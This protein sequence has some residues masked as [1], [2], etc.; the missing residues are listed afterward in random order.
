[1]PAEWRSLKKGLINI[2]NNDQKRFLWCH[3]RHINFVKIYPERIR[4]NDEKLA[5][6]LNYGEVGF[7]L[8]EKDFG[9]IEI[10][11]NICIN[12]FGY[13]NKLVFP[14]HISDQKFENSMDLLLLIDESKSHYVYIKDFDRFMFHKT[15]NKIK[16]HFCKSC[17][18]SFSSQNVLTGHEEICLK[19]NVA[20]SV[21]FEKGT[22]EF[23]NYFR[24][25]SVSF[26]IYVDFESNLESVESYEGSYSKKNIIIIL[27]VVLL[28]NLFLLVIN[29]LSQQFFNAILKE[30]EYCNKVMKKNFNKSLIMTEKEKEQF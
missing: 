12:V 27:F 16:K 6:D 20:Q 18:Q 5:D 26:K 17:L 30:Y 23:K 13:E 10:K 14:I 2:K 24:Q 19:I 21:R 15:K 9:K 29:L 28:T 1:M 8:W 3:V 7:P 22:I 4:Q 25:I 11:S